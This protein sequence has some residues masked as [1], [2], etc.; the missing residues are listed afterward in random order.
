[1]LNRRYLRIKVYQ[2]LYAYGQGEHAST[3]AVEKELHQGID[4]THDL[5][6][7]LL[8]AFGELRHVAELRMEDRKKK[9]LPTAADLDP[10]RRFVEHVI[11]R[12]IAQSERLRLECE[13]RRV[14]WVG[15]M[16]LFTALFKAM[17]ESDA[18]KAYMAETAPSFTKDRAFA[19]ELLS[20]QIA[21]SE[22][23][24]D[25]FEGRSIYWLEDLDLAAGLVKRVL[26]Q[27]RVADGGD[28]CL[29]GL[30]HDPV[31][32]RAFVNDL[33]RQSIVLD[34]EHEA[35][36]AAKASNWDTDR[37]AYTDMILMKMALTEARIFD[38]IPVKVTLNE[39]IEIAKAYSTPKSKLFINGVLDKLFAEM[40][41]DGRIRKVGR[42]L[43]ES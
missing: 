36:I 23:I 27:W 39:Y 30:T 29:N 3:A 22:S 35:L 26:E 25:V 40:K 8:L 6:L 34:S 15:H 12:D 17:E 10:S 13:K 11:V 42:G 41:A 7:A 33:F 5:Y 31:E 16:E 43:L 38:Q 32:E 19:V 9:H 4:R 24:Q 18:Y 2:A 37:I 14:S 28:Q 21:N 20:E 1:M